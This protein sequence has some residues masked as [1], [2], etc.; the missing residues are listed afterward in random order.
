M[1]VWAIMKLNF[2]EAVYGKKY[3]QWLSDSYTDD[4]GV[5]C[6]IY[7]MLIAAI[8]DLRDIEDNTVHV[9]M[10]RYI[11]GELEIM[12]KIKTAFKDK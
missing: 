8:N 2:L 12:D 4:R 11:D 7:G 3:K 1:T 6:N 10:N 5:Y 9:A